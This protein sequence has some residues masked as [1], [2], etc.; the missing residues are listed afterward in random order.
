[1]ALPYIGGKYRMAKWISSFIPQQM[2]TYVEVFGG[3]FWTFLKSNF[4]ANK[5]YYND[6]NRH[7]SNLFASMMVYEEFHKAL[8][9]DNPQDQKLFDQY[10]QEILDIIHNGNKF[11]LP[12]IDIAQKYSYLVTQVF[13]GIMTDNAKMVNLKGKYRSKYDSF[14]DKMVNPKFQQRFDMITDVLNL[15]FEKLI[16]LLDSPDTV[17]YVDPPYYGTEN[18][19]AFHEFGL[20]QHKELADIL[21]SCKG[22]WLLS[23][24]E[25]DD[26]SK[27]FPKDQYHW[28]YKEFKK[29]SMASKG[30]GQTTGV[31]VLVMNYNPNQKK[32]YLSDFFNE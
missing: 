30:K 12:N 21:K 14:T 8:C 29:A 7:M 2:E 5:V 17:F 11:D 22:K 31:E 27:W 15:S 28:E 24:Y 1:M 16:P 9:S 4:T 23:Y 18:L 32:E 19:Y 6:F 10:K 3:A 13:S 20:E 25:F 26:L